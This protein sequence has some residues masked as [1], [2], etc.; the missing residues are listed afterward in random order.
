MIEPFTS[1]RG[2]TTI[3]AGC[4]DRPAHDADRRRRSATTSA[5]PHSYV[6]RRA[7]CATASASARSPTCA[8][9]A[10]ARARARPARSWRSRTPTSARAR[11][12]RTSPTSATPTSAR[13]QPRRRHDHRQLRRPPKH[14]TTIGAGVH[15]GVDTTLVAPVDRRRR[16]LHRRRLGDHRGRARTARSAS[17]ARARRNVEGYAERAKERERAVS[18]DVVAAPGVDSHAEMSVTEPQRAPSTTARHR[19]RQAPDAVRGPRATRSSP[20][21]S[22]ASSGSS[23]ARSTLKTFSNGEVYCR[24]EESIRGAD[25]FIVQPT[26]GNPRPGSPPTTR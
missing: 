20:H 19:L 1:L 16:R 4:H 24:Y 26:C 23:S 10:A 17:R 2:A 18:P 6:D 3:G 13:H 9:H 14:R 21:A 8:R 12:S 11:R 7:R 22:P 15:G 5:I 25:V